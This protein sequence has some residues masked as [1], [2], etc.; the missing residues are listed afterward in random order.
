MVVN[1]SHKDERHRSRESSRA[2]SNMKIFVVGLSYKTA[3]VEIREQVAV[4]PSQVRCL[5]C[6]LKISSGLSEVVVVST[7]N[8]VEIY[9]LTSRV[10]VQAGKL[11][12]QLCKSDS[13]LRPHLFV[14]EDAD[15]VRHLFS[16]AGGMDSMVLGETE[17]T[18]Q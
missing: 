13:D 12:S 10:H 14:Y 2:D 11:F 4:K 18:G 15:A 5:G 6:R 8:R 16:V 3:P 1:C 9:G 7:C 17:I